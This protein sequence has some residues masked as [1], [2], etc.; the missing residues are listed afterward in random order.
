MVVTLYPIKRKT[1]LEQ[2]IQW[3]I[4]VNLLDFKDKKNLLS[5]TK[6]MESCIKSKKEKFNLY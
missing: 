2:S 1:D 5:D 4:L 6:K 3:Y